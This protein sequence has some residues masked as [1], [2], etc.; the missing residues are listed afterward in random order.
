MAHYLGKCFHPYVSV[1]QS[2]LSNYG[3]GLVALSN[4]PDARAKERMVGLMGN[5]R[6]MFREMNEKLAQSFGLDMKLLH[7]MG[8]ISYKM[9]QDLSIQKPKPLT[10][11]E[12]EA[13]AKAVNEAAMMKASYS[14]PSY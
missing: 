7:S 12:N 3:Q 8:N 9:F 11:Q 13:K 1:K 14:T 10:R 4:G 6:D 2:M 5:G